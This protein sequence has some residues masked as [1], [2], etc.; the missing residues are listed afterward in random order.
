[1]EDLIVEVAQITVASTCAFFRDSFSLA[2]SETATPPVAQLNDRGRLS[3]VISV[4]GPIN[5][6]IVFNFSS[7]I[8]DL[9]FER[10][11]TEIYVEPD[12]EDLYRNEA[13]AEVANIAMGH[14]TTHLCRHDQSIQL[15]PP[16]VLRDVRQ[17]PRLRATVVHSRFLSTPRGFFE[18]DFI[19][20]RSS[21]GA[22]R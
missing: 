13:V 22:A 11:K 7:S 15:S 18:I 19:G 6:V 21:R 2:V 1:V 4:A 5:C 9:L 3:A 8:V 17:I 16:F 14:A 20:S 12:Q 10:L